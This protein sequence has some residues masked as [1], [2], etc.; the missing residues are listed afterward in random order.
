[1]SPL[2]QSIE[3]LLI[4]F[5]RGDG[6]L[7]VVQRVFVCRCWILISFDLGK[8]PNTGTTKSL[9]TSSSS[10]SSSSC[11]PVAS[12]KCSKMKMNNLHDGVK[13][14]FTLTQTF[15]TDMK[16]LAFSLVICIGLPKMRKIQP[17]QRF[18]ILTL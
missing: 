18:Y 16:I 7:L 11:D 14:F 2:Q 10:S 4:F 12:T 8:N 17:P 15:D 9:S 3:Q 1:V 5:L 6:E 13:V